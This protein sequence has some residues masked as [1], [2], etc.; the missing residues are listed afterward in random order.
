MNVKIISWNVRVLNDRDKR[1]RVRNMI[2]S[3]GADIICL[4]ETKMEFISKREIRSLWGC[5]HVDWLYLGSIGASG[6]VL[7]MW[8]RRTV[9]K[10]DGAVG[11]FSVSCKFKN[12]K[13]QFEWAFTGIYGPNSAHDRQFL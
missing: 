10:I 13:D 12:V 6:G 5:Q 8:D 4:Q 9:E 3:W 7:V 11:R 2:K 1:L